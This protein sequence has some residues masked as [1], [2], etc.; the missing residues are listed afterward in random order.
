MGLVVWRTQINNVLR[1]E[2]RLGCVIFH[3][4]KVFKELS[5]NKS[6]L[7]QMSSYK[8]QHVCTK[9]DWFI[10]DSLKQTFDSYT[11]AAEVFKIEY[12]N[13]TFN[14]AGIRNLIKNKG[15]NEKTNNKYRKIFVFKDDILQYTFKT[16]IEFANHFGFTLSSACNL[17]SGK[18]KSPLL[19]DYK[20]KVVCDIPDIRLHVYDNSQEQICS[21][22]EQSKPLNHQNY[23]YINTE[24]KIFHK[25]C[26]ECF[27]NSMYDK[28]LND[29]MK[30][31][32]NSWKQ[33][34]IYTYL[35]FERDTTKIF[36]EQSA[37][38]IKCDF[39]IDNKILM[40]RSLKWEA[41]YGKI[42]EHHI[43]R[44]KNKEFRELQRDDS[45]THKFK[46][47]KN[48]GIELD[49]LEC[50]LLYCETC[51]KIIENPKSMDQVYC[52]EKCRVNK[53]N[54]EC[55]EKRN[56]NLYSYINQ[57]VYSQKSINRR[58]KT[59]VDYNTDYLVSL[60][61]NCFYCGIECK[62]GYSIP[63]NDPGT[64]SYDKKDPDIGYI[65][66]NVV[67]CCWFC[68]R[69]KN[70]TGYIDWEQFISF[71]KK[72]E[73][74]V[75]DLSNK[76]Y[77]KKSSEINTSNIWFHVRKKSPSYY[78]DTQIPK[79]VFKNLCKQQNYL[80]PYFKF[81]PIIYLE[82]NCLFNAS[83][84]AIDTRLPESEKHRPGNLQIVPKCFNYGKND[85]SN[86]EFMECWKVRGFKTDFTECSIKYPDGYHEQSYF[87]NNLCTK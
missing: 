46:E 37:M 29:F 43:I 1:I 31:L 62:F 2:N 57:K 32:N 24:K 30:L 42:P 39:E 19:K 15:C 13:Q 16:N 59:I 26:I 49:N 14:E 66:E 87:H 51:K 56:T 58:Y 7:L 78:P 80:D 71:I 83:L 12:N 21:Y 27:S 38:Y 22:C 67:V 28:R 47:Y 8:P 60:G 75:L 70:Q 40:L 23:N 76:V 68:N 5:C 81:F 33:H 44:Y 45:L 85:N 72:K 73:L 52:S 69:M 50:V 20:I 36:N 53:T 6:T 11:H 4:S 82:T 64:L 74:T 65:K 17:I 77:A 84:D 10:N 34:P 61:L 18:Q 54:E 9:L 35:Y 86:E 3:N 63:T 48:E 55:K 79:Q 41:F 25:K